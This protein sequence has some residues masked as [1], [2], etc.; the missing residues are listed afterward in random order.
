LK[1]NAEAVCY[2]AL[3]VTE[4]LF[5]VVTVQ[6]QAVVPP[7]KLFLKRVEFREFREFR[8]IPRIPAN[9]GEFRANS[10][11]IPGRSP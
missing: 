8:G 4:K 3:A 1:V 11:R 5:R 7:A 9:S 2:E 6:C 10:G